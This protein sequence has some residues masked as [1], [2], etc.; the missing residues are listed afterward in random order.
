MKLTEIINH[1]SD[2]TEDRFLYENS[3]NAYKHIELLQDKLD[4]GLV[5]SGT[6]R[7]YVKHIGG[8][9]VMTVKTV[10]TDDDMVGLLHSD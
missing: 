7:L 5:I 6:K 9:T 3:E 1:H 2:G 4:L 10:Y 8:D